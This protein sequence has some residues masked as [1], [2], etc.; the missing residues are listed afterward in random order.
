[1]I[2]II[3]YA[4]VKKLKNCII[5]QAFEAILFYKRQIIPVN[6]SGYYYAVFVSLLFFFQEPVFPQSVLPGDITLEYIFQD[7][8][9]INPRPSLKFINT[10]SSK[11]YYYADDD[12]DGRLSLFDFNYSSFETY[13]YND[14]MVAASEYVISPGGDALCV[15]KGDVYVSKNFTSTGEFTK[16]IR[17][18]ETDQYEYSPVLINNTAMYRRSGNYYLRVF[19]GSGPVT[20]ELELT[21][22]E[23]D[24]ISYQVMA[25]TLTYNDTSGTLIRILFARYNNSGKKELVFPDFTGEYVKAQKQKRGISSVK[26]LEFEIRYSGN[27]S[28]YSKVTQITLP[29]SVRY[30]VNYASYSPDAAEIIFDAETLNRKTRKLFLYNI[31]P[32]QVNEIYSENDD[33]WFERHSNATFFLNENDIFFESEISGYNNLYKI[34]KDGSGFGKIAGGNYTIPES[35]VD[36]KSGTVYFIANQEHPCEYYIYSSGLNGDNFKQLTFDKGD[37]ED[38]KIS[39]DGKYLFYSH[40][41][42]DKPNEL[43]MYDLLKNTAAQ[44]TSTVSPAF[45]QVQ[46]VL[47]GLITF[48]N[49]EDRELIHAFL[50][51]PANY[52]PKKKYPLICFAHGAGYLQNVTMG[53]SPYRDNFMVNTYLTS[54]GYIVL[55]VDFRGSKGYG[56]EFRN[57]T[58]RNLGYWEVSDYISGINYL[59]NS[60]LIER[61]NVGIYG[62]SY[63]GFITLSAM[64]SH[65]DIFKCGAAL[66]AVSDW[67]NY[68]FNNWWYTLARFGDYDDEDV[69]QYYRLSSP[70]YYAE[71]LKG[72]L[73]LLH[74]MLDDNV[75]FQQSVH[76]TQ[77]LIDLK[78]DFEIMYY[79]ME[80]HSF[81]RQSSWLD[82]YKRISKFFEKNLK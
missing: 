72:P 6:L 69:K 75:F 4:N 38:L 76:L 66:R 79:P 55:D 18:T 37:A 78:K 45:S 8:N 15:I 7:T 62:G 57:K 29:D 63:G 20:N 28:L 27:D 60:G 46:W 21:G 24:S 48:Q 71:G 65:A 41:Y 58:Y 53:F 10:N 12:F 77:K 9:I 3:S 16:D 70:L 47:P 42:L 11:I 50:Y 19:N 13:K 35:A 73:L 22:D 39:A 67:G 81:H 51:K 64:F 17:L 30:S 59:S 25:N 2:N 80:N 56:R 40:S 61:N 52:N 68:S 36:R 31:S 43:Y 74:G 14:T 34:N 5:N 32:Q 54:L 82:Q 44:I 23:S 49:E 1:M 26:F 33:A